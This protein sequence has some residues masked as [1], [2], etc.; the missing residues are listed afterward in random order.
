MKKR[1]NMKQTIR[2]MSIGAMTFLFTACGSNSGNKKFSTV[3]GLEVTSIEEMDVIG[4]VEEGNIMVADLSKVGSPK[5]ML[6]SDLA[7]D[8]RIVK[9]DNSDD[10]LVKDGNVWMS[11]K[12]FIIFDGSEVKQF[13]SNGKYLGKIGSRG[14]GPGEYFIA[15]YD[16]AIDEDRGRIYLLAYGAE[17]LL[18]YDLDGKF[19]G[20]VPLAHKAE[21]G[22]IDIEPDG[23]LTIG[24]LIFSDAAEPYTIWHQGVDGVM[25]EGLEA[26][27]LGVEP[28]Y[29]NEVFKG[30]GE[31]G[32]TYSLFRLDAKT[33]TLY[34]YAGGKLMPAFTADFSDS[35]QM[36]HYASFPGFYLV[37]V[38]G[39]PIEVGEGS[40][41]L[42]SE[43]PVVIDKKTGKGGAVELVL[44]FIGPI[45]A[46][47]DWIF[48][49]NPDYFTLNMDPGDL[50]DALEKIIS[51]NSGIGE[52]DLRQMKELLDGISPDDNNYLIVG[53]W[54]K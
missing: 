54:K 39:K 41:I 8:V 13:D 45:K 35:R 31:N 12:R 50:A 24:A 10:A 30:R 16:I 9:L 37:D 5:A 47:K 3:D 23:S 17:K 22:F 2:L 33:D 1:T 36:H 4:S 27:N 44:D 14:N 26:A 28:D 38:I 48:A 15:P 53:K 20:D 46:G 7:D 19:V 6:L 21:K 43:T 18:S 42:P 49:K 11:D 51:R 29:S 40:F 32:F 52:S 25:T 34:E